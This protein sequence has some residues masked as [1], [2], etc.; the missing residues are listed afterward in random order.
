MFMK[1]QNFTKTLEPPVFVFAC[2]LGL[3]GASCSF[4]GVER[5]SGLLEIFYF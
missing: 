5:Q 4:I 3:L 1:V 2:V